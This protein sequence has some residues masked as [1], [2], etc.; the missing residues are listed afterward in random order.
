[1]T[2][3]NTRNFYRY[4]KTACHRFDQGEIAEPFARVDEGRAN[5]VVNAI[6]GYIRTNLP[7]AIEKRDS[8]SKYRTNPYALMTSASIMTQVYQCLG[9]LWRFRAFPDAGICINICF[10]SILNSATSM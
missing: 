7:S 9:E 6:S 3:R 10:T 5:R 4:I 8:Q 1:M 2:P